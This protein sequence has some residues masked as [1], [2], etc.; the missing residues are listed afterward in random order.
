MR[1]VQAFDLETYRNWKS[2]QII[3]LGPPTEKLS[4]QEII[5]KVQRNE[6]PPVSIIPDKLH[7]QPSTSDLLPIKKPWES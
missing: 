7:T 3:H 5:Q 4:F 2:S 1:F 6:M